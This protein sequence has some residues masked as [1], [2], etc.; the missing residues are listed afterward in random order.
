M[1]SLKENLHIFNQDIKHPT[2]GN[3]GW[4]LDVYSPIS[5]ELRPGCHIKIDSGFGLKLPQGMVGLFTPKESSPY[6]FS[7]SPGQIIHPEFSS[8][9]TLNLTY[10]GRNNEIV[11][12]GDPLCQILLLSAFRFVE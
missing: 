1:L 12:K 3:N 8:E 10:H 5:F 4:S 2:I 9:L 6:H 11:R 7:V